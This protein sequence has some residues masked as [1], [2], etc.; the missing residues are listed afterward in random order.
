MPVRKR[1]NKWHYEFMKSGKR[2]SG[3]CEGCNTQAQAEKYLNTIKAK[4][5]ATATARNVEQLYEIR[6]QELTGN[7]GIALADAFAESL[8]YSTR[9]AS[10]KKIRQKSNAFADFVAFMTDKHAEIKNISEVGINHANEYSSYL[11]NNGKYKTGVEYVRDGKTITISN[12]NGGRLANSTI[13]YYIQVCTEVF[14]KLKIDAGLR[15][16]PFCQYKRLPKQEEVRE[17]FTD[18]EIKLIYEKANDFVKPLFVVA[19]NTGLREGDICTLRKRE[20][21]LIERK[22]QRTQNKTA[23]KV[24]IPIM[25][26][27]YDF[28]I[29]WEKELAEK[30]EIAKGEKNKTYHKRW[31]YLKMSAAD[32]EEYA[33]YIFPEQAKLYKENKDG[34]SYRIKEFLE[35]IGIKTTRTPEGRTRAVSIKDLHSC[36]HTFA[37]RAADAGVSIVTVQSI[38]GH[39]TEAMSMHYSSHA[40]FKDKQKAMAKISDSTDSRRLEIL[41]RL[42][43]L[44]TDKLEKL[45]QML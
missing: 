8:K 9:K 29:Q 22:I 41:D 7:A 11:I 5:G 12:G 1:G 27:L 14:E 4:Q 40:T 32:Y 26:E 30:I 3:V 42:A 21:D 33:D 24:E 28:L 15:Y 43:K 2:Y 31:K 36:R 10:E 44:P 18:E 39:L 45:L 38:L 34:V 35:G 6:H 19:M 25:P 37:K 13:N 16:N 20:V 23:N 17:V